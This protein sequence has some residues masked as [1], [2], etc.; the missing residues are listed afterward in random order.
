MVLTKAKMIV[1]VAALGFQARKLVLQLQELQAF[2]C[3]HFLNGEPDA[4]CDLEVGAS[5]VL[6]CSVFHFDLFLS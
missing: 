1:L 4:L 3:F 2:G 6:A 5:C